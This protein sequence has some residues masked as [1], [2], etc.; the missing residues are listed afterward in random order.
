V[1]SYEE[2]SSSNRLRGSLDLLEEQR[3]EAHLRALVDKKA[4]TR[5]HDRR[6]R[7][8]RIEVGNLVLRKAEVSDLTWSRGKLAPN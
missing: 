5:L 4:I 1:E 3:A 8:R 2:P 7:P 6:V